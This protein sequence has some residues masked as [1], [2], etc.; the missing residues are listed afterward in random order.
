MFLGPKHEEKKRQKE[1]KIKIL[2]NLIIT[3][4]YLFVA[5]KYFIAIVVRAD[6]DGS[7]I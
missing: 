7:V 5:D 1:P 6:D 4:I 2:R 3:N